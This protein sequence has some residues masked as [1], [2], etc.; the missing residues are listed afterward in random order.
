MKIHISVVGN[1]Y[2]L[3]HTY[4]MFDVTLNT[5][6]FHLILFTPPES[7]KVEIW[8]SPFY[9]YYKWDL[10]RLIQFPEVAQPVCGRPRD[11]TVGH[12][13]AHLGTHMSI[14]TC[15]VDH[16]LMSCGCRVSSVHVHLHLM[17]ML[18]L[19]EVKELNFCSPGRAH[20]CLLQDHPF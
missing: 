14:Y 10:T 8:L 12:L 13:T 16:P 9:G 20:I 2:H 11:L 3:L 5:V 7:I 1:R 19:R 18:K 15:P 4:H 17:K 6:G